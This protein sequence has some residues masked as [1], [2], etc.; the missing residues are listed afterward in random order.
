MS[1]TRNLAV[2]RLLQDTVIL[3]A[4]ALYETLVKLYQEGHRLEIVTKEG[5]RIDPLSK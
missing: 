5:E 3:D 2:D 1:T 4:I